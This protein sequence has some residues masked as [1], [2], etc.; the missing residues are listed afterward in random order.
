MSKITIENLS[1]ETAAIARAKTR[2][3]WGAVALNAI[4]IPLSGVTIDT[5]DKSALATTAVDDAWLA[6]VAGLPTVS[7]RGLEFLSSALGDK[8]WVS[9]D[10]A[11]R[12]VEIE[13]SQRDVAVQAE[14]AKAAVAN[15]GAAMLLARAESELP[16]TLARV[17]ENAK[18]I[19]I[20]AVGVANFTKEVAI[21]SGKSLGTAAGWVK[22]IRG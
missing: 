22:S 15:R 7:R 12:F 13:K 11:L 3:S 21:L 17:A 19:A 4:S 9:I 16:G 1:Q 6:A 8:G 2:I 10:E 20:A 18:D 14:A 5:E